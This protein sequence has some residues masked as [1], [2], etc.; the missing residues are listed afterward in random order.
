MT[1]PRVSKLKT[2]FVAL[3]ASLGGTSAMLSLATSA[4]ALGTTL[5]VSSGG[6]DSGGCASSSTPSATVSYA[7][8]QASN[9]DEIEVAGTIQDNIAITSLSSITIAQWPSQSP[10]VIAGQA[11]NR[12]VIS[13]TSGGL[14]TIDGVT[15]ESG[16]G[17]LGGGITNV[18]STVTVDDSTIS[19]N[20]T[21]SEAGG[22]YNRYGTLNVVDSTF[23]GN[24]TRFYGGAI[25]NFEGTASI[26]DS[27]FA[28]NTSENG[29]D[30]IGNDV[31]TV[32]VDSST[33]SGD[34]SSAVWSN[35]SMTFA[36]DI[37]AT[38][39]GPP[40]GG[41]CTGGG[42][43]TDAGY[44][45]SDDATCALS[46]GQNSVNDSTTI[47]HYLGPLQNN[48]GSTDT[49]VLLPGNGSSPN[50]AEY[51]IPSSFDLPGGTSACAEPDQRD[52]TRQIPCDAGAYALLELFALPNGTASAPCTTESSTSSS[53]CSLETA[54]TEA[55]GDANDVVNLEVPTGN[56]LYTGVGGIG[57][58]ETI[59]APLALQADPDVGFDSATPSLDGEGNGTVLAVTADVDVSVTGVTIENGAPSGSPGGAILNGGTGTLT[60]ASSTFLE[61]L[62]GGGGALSNSAGG[63]LDVSEST[64]EGNVSDGGGAIA[65]GEFG[66]GTLNVTDSTFLD[67]AANNYSGGAILNGYDSGGDGTASITDSTFDGNTANFDD[68]GAIDN[69][70]AGGT[71]T[72][73]ITGSTFADTPGEI[74]SNS[75]SVTVAS[76][77]FENDCGQQGETWLD[78]GYNVGS[79]GSCFNGGAGDDDSAGS[80]LSS[81]VGP[82]ADNGGPTETM[83]LATGNPG[84][85]IIPD[86]TTGLC[87]VASDQRGS[88]SPT[89]DSCDAGAVQLLAAQ[90]IGSLSTAPTDAVVGGAT[91][92]PSASAF[93]GLPVSI[94]VDPSTS[95]ECSISGGGLV[96]FTAIGTCEVDFNQSGN[97][98]WDAAQQVQQTFT[99][100]AHVGL[101]ELFALPNGTASA[102]CTT[103]SSTSSSV[104]SLETAITE[105]DGDANDVVNLEAPTGN[106]LYTGV[107]GIGVNETISAPLALQ[108]DPDVGF[109]NATP[110]LDG[111]GNGTVLAVTADVDVSVT[112][113]TIENGAPSGSPGGAILNGGTGTLTIASSTFLE[114]LDGGGGA[115]SNSAGGTLDVSESTF[116]GNVSDGGGAIANGEFGSGTLNVTDSTFLD[117]AANNYSGGAILNG[118]DSGG[119]GTASITDSTFD[120]NTANFDDRGAI[121]NGGAGGTGTITITGSTFADTP[122][123]IQSNSGSVTVASDVFENDCGQQGETWLDNGYNVGSD[124]SCFNGGAGDDDSA[125]SGLSSLVG[126]LADN[127]GPTETMELATGNPGI[128]IIP[129]PTTGLCPVASDQRGSPSPTGDSCDAGAVQLLAAQSIGSLS[130][131]PTDAVVGGATYTPSA[132]AFSGLPVSITVDPSTSSECSISGGGL[133]S[134]TAIGTCEVDFNQSG[135]SEWDAAQQVQQTFTVS[136]HV[137]SSPLDATAM[138]S[139]LTPAF[140]ATVSWSSPASDGGS[141]VSGYTV[142][143]Y[144]LTSSE[145]GPAARVLGSATSTAMS[146][147]VAGD[148]YDF[149]VTASNSGGDGPSVNTN[150]VVPVGVAPSGPSDIDTA[151]SADASG[152]ATASLGSSGQPGSISSTA[153]GSGAVSVSKYPSNPIPMAKAE[154]TFYDVSVAPGQRF[155]HLTFTVC[156]VPVGVQLRWWDPYHAPLDYSARVQ[157]ERTQR[158]GIVCNRHDRQHDEPRLV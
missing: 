67:N 107:G 156:G 44:N 126:P 4:G 71:G 21:T 12:T 92:T 19:D 120:G 18:S 124:G 1:P 143:S 96:S 88:P 133:V 74:Q 105:A 75:G 6:T 63:T 41:E 22:I 112:G 139:G 52:V 30:A 61:N 56:A 144:N 37:L 14:V 135:N 148:L 123:E 72:I 87:P 100:S 142:A 79:D 47:D 99:V 90:S 122:G 25:F 13:V 158:S 26:S 17:S 3:L 50:P 128:G 28:G 127:G 38:S 2:L 91:Y 82:L 64:F 10:A 137:P 16:S 132:S 48:G 23:T 106:A 145:T 80:G 108:A 129:D 33:I 154:G 136:A 54:I 155:G 151:T 109:D 20:S 81:L 94:T 86:P 110:S 77:V 125:G 55:D 89:G 116:E 66:S 11:G 45:V 117:N 39:G 78:N 7:L 134:F 97:S 36:A 118:Y 49:I 119:D 84:I 153:W 53:V 138:A 113:V 65:N 131:A 102:P 42:E 114:N 150:M 95:S 98:E 103:E 68:G 31:G 149:E 34:T 93:S 76:D 40:A 73:T 104:C 5:F 70:G 111:E 15:V 141:S 83:E 130:T 8:S 147:L 29:G 115:L 51:V 101:L 43:F 35:G 85:G 121:D 59:S 57:V 157:S 58:N 152:H 24:A 60:I 69:G 27:T 46:A 32:T 140:G 62:D 146:G 9:G